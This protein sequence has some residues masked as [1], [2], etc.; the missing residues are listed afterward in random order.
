LEDKLKEFERQK[1]ELMKLKKELAA[2]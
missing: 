1:E 2:M